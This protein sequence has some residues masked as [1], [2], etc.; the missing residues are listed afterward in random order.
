MNI[1]ANF[2]ESIEIECTIEYEF[3]KNDDYQPFINLTFYIKQNNSRYSPIDQ[4]YLN[5][6]EDSPMENNQS[7]NWKRSIRYRMKLM[8]KEENY[9]EYVC[10]VIPDSLENEDLFQNNHRL[11]RTKIDIRRKFFFD[12]L[13]RILFYI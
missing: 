6:I 4:I 11:C 1:T 8:D 9:R 2:D 7:L 5:D 3:I 12:Q 13:I 10:I